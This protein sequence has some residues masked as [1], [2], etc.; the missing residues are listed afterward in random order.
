[1]KKIVLILAIFVIITVS[2]L[3]SRIPVD[4]VIRVTSTFAEFRLD[5]FHSGVD[6]GG[7]MNVFPIED[8][9][10]IYYF[11]ELEDPTKQMFGIG[12]FMI[13]EHSSGVR[14]YYYHLEA[15]T[16]QKE[17][18]KVITR[19]PIAISGNSGR[20]GG[21]HLH[22]TIE[23]LKENTVVDPLNYLKMDKGSEQSP[24]IHGIYLR[25]DERLIQIRDKSV[26]R[27][28]GELRL[29]VK[30]YDLL[31][32]LPMGLKRI[33]IYIN[34]EIVRDYDFTYLIKK[35]NTYYIY[36]NYTFEEVYG[37]DPHFY[38]GGAFTPKRGNYTFRVEATDFDDKTVTLSRTVTFR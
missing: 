33:K 28:N 1:M 38:R 19:D 14:S 21:T 16:I 11:D 23:N 18:A 35:D 31:G 37:V 22:L 7:R 27:Y 17:Y 5:H 13:L 9:E 10:I 36:P 26:M 29:F 3:Y 8:G 30:A 24:L 6:L 12:N 15:G 34:D 2:I 32:S 20:S 4:G 25:T